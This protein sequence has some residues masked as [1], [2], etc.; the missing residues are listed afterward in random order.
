MRPTE[1][2]R[3]RG[4]G[5]WGPPRRR[6]GWWPENEPW[7]PQG[8]EAWRSLRRG[9]MRR[10]IGFALVAALVLVTLVAAMIWLLSS[11]FGAGWLS[12]VLGILILIILAGGARGMVRN[13]R[14]MV[15]PLGDLIE[16]SARVEAG[17]V[18][19]QVEVRGPN[20]VRALARAF[21][22]MSGR[23]A[24]TDAERR[25]LLADVSH[26]L[27]TPLT[28]I[29]GN[30]EGIADGLYP[31]DRP[32]LERILAET[33]HMERLID[34]L[35]TLSL[36]DAGALILDRQPTDLGALAAEVVAGFGPQAAAAGVTLEAD[37]P[38]DLPDL[39]LD[40]LRIRQVVTNL[41]A[42]ALRHTPSGGKVSV[43]VRRVD[44]WVALEVADSGSGMDA[45]SA[46]RA[47]DRFWRSGDSPGAGLGLAIVRDLVQAH[48]GEV[49]LETT[50]GAGTAVRCRFPTEA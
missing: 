24:E 35:R 15:V 39:E 30:V 8:P 25:R 11:A 3:W 28:V 17:E 32:T 14:G 45:A 13:T 49:S 16:A 34:D 42:N 6:P 41:V 2:E 38:D 23:L 36:A 21:N 5:G 40:P 7:P 43:S 33:R 50:P 27:R 20:E 29:Q 47:F 44:S 10:F 18:G 19:T 46:A 22:A 26:E 1:H 9:F 48:G 37:A 31:A 4:R 12:A